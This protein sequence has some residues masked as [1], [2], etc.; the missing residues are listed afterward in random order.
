MFQQTIQDLLSITA[1]GPRA[2]DL[3]ERVCAT[4][5]AF[6]RFESGELLAH[7]EH[8][9][10]RFLLAPGLGEVG[11][12]ALAQLGGERTL[13]LD[14][15]AQLQESGLNAGSGLA[16]L[17]VLRLEAPSVTSAAIVLGH[18]RPW[19]F[20]AAPLSRVRTIASVALRLLVCGSAPTDNSGDDFELMAEI[21]RLR[22]HV[23][24]LKAEIMGL[25]AD[26]ARRGYDKPR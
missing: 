4:I 5:L 10:S 12:K 25:R 18:S 20:A 11:R 3:L 26:L 6:E 8:G 19:S 1:A 13:R 14:T 9:S 7:T 24:T 16:S 21:T 2:E 22:T 15:A 17:L 23:S